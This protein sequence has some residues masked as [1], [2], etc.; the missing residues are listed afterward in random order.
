MK[1][2]QRF[3]LRDGRTTHTSPSHTKIPVCS[4][5]LGKL[6]ASFVYGVNFGEANP[7]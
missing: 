6:R 7:S 5:N 3:P 2:H 4:I 1:I